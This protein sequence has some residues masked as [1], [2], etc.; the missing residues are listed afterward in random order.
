MQMASRVASIQHVLP[1]LEYSIGDLE[2]FM[3]GETLEFHYGKHHR[4]Y[5]DKVNSLIAGTAFEGAGLENIVRKSSGAIFNNAAQV[6][7]HNFFW[8]CLD[9]NGGGGPPGELGGAI[10][11]GFGSVDAFR[12]HFK[13]VAAEKFGSGWTWLVRTRDGQLAV[14]NTDDAD[15]PLRSG[16]AALLACD[17]WE[18]AYYIDYRN[19]RGKYLDAFWNIVNWKFVQENLAGATMIPSQAGA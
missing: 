9:P 10:K 16:D 7:N 1:D 18:H 5:V 3:S 4:G 17:V 11:H 6:W 12:Q 13:K 14:R 8:K 2:P 19:D 15:N